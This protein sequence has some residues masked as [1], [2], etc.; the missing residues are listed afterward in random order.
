MD[1]LKMGLYSKSSHQ[2]VTEGAFGHIYFLLT[3]FK[4]LL[5]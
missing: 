2:E 5:L 1:C 4:S 3:Y